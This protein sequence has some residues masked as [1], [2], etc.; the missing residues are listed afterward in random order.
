M[1][2]LPARLQSIDV[3]R[4][5]TMFL[6]IFVNDVSSV[7]AIPHWIDHVDG[8]ADGMGFADTIFP[9]FL[10]I[11]GLSLPFA[12]R[13]RIK[14]GAS[15]PALLG[16]IAVRSAALI[17]MGFFHVNLESYNSGASL[18][19]LPVWELLV[20]ISFFL[21]WMQYPEN[22][23]RI[24]K[25]ILIAAGVFTLVFLALIYKGGETGELHGMRPSWWGILGII[26][27]AYLVSAL[28]FVFVKGKWLL[29][30]PFVFLLINGLSHAGLM[31]FSLPIIGDAASVTLV[32]NGIFI[33]VM[34]ER[35]SKNGNAGRLWLFLLLTC[36]AWIILGFVLRPYT[37]G[38]S[39]IRATPAWVLICSGISV[40][41][42][43]LMI[44]LVDLR[45]KQHWFTLIRPAGTSTL[46][47]YLI[48]YILYSLFALIRFSYPDL[49]NS[50]Y[51]GIAR[52]FAVSFVVIIIAG[53]LEKIPV[54][55]KV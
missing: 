31:P 30:M 54:K 44:W 35:L 50:G 14:K 21:V 34:Y 46:T 6:M 20:T 51:P 36:A 7:S 40:A 42:F 53:Q 27:W 28:V 32:M 4:A 45:K 5:I 52:S 9:A 2:T 29:A 37:D 1:Q 23:S 16:Y 25:I 11:V 41:V 3:F 10:F 33:S 13:N 43:T 17:I 18:L 55:L 22:F 49:L 26:G 47:C 38:I 24:W 12:I 8:K 39:K 19:S 15:T 48:P